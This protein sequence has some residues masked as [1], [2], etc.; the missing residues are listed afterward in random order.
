MRTPS[1]LKTSLLGGVVA[2]FAT[3]S[4][5]EAQGCR[6]SVEIRGRTCIGDTFQFCWD[7]S[8]GCDVCLFVDFDPGPFTIF[9]LT[10]NVSPNT[11]LYA[12]SIIGPNGGPDCA[13]LTIPN[14]PALA[15]LRLYY[16]SLAYPAGQPAFAETGDYGY[17][18]VCI[19]GAIGDDVWCDLNDDGIRDPNEPGIPDA[20]VLL[21]CDP[22]VTAETTTD[23]NGK[24]LFDPVYP[25]DC[26]VTV[27]PV[28]LPSNK[29]PGTNCPVS[30][31]VGLQSGQTF[32]DADFCV[33][34]CNPCDGKV[35]ALTLLY[36]GSAP[37][38][39]I[40]VVDRDGRLL[41]QGVVDPGQSF[42]FIGLKSDGTMTNDIRIAVNGGAPLQIH[43]S[44]SQ[45]I[46][47]GSVFGDFTV[48]RGA[49]RYGGALCKP[50]VCGDRPCSLTM[51]YLGGDCSRTSTLQ[52]SGK[53]SCTGSAGTSATVRILATDNQDPF[54]TGVRV[55]FDG[56]VN[57]GD[58]FELL[59]RNAGATELSSDSYV[60]ILD[61]SNHVLQSIKFHTSCSQP[62]ILGDRYGAVRLEGYIPKNQ[63]GGGSG[64]NPNLCD[65][66]GRPEVLR[67]A[68][69]GG[70]CSATSNSQ[71]P[72]KYSCS[73]TLNGAPMVMMLVTD[74]VDPADP[75]ARVYFRGAVSIDQEFDIDGNGSDL[76]SDT[77]VHV[78]DP[79]GAS[80]QE[81]RFHTSCSQPLRM[82]DQFGC[83]RIV[84][85]IR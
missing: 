30:V 85:I 74:K 66:F 33:I 5:L 50:S 15:G 18:E 55:W 70:D 52:D 23:S 71:D 13:P 6:P 78:M 45:P 11:F 26:R 8:P 62:L 43:T 44:C 69:T 53:W 47:P 2:L 39:S 12:K 9:G 61:A 35:T 7:A 72:S 81:V 41:F 36:N 32:L 64:G 34:D 73:G 10:L 24:Y 68:Y 54:R 27:D 19:P 4:Q 84:T 60:H 21:D 75:T 48:L 42:S 17:I 80:L 20:R 59:A 82:G 63:C 25:G 14:D 22:N 79:Q 65:T 51:R 3:A 77:Y 49:S 56:I 57:L 31:M 16:Q 83:I 76:R 28:S 46:G 38:A 40:V 1:L 58:Q 67:V 29:A 37:H